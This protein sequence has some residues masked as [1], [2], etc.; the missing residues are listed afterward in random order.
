LTAPF[1]KIQAVT[2]QHEST[3][4]PGNTDYTPRAAVAISN[5]QSTASIL[6]CRCED[7]R[8]PVSASRVTISN[9]DPLPSSETAVNSKIKSGTFNKHF[10]E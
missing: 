5:I 6:E 9:H 4:D 10:S 2:Q 7:G 3:T 8:F 1:Q